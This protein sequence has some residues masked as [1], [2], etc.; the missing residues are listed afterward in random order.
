MP[1]A[2]ALQFAGR[3][4][5][6]RPRESVDDE[7]LKQGT[8]DEGLD[9]GSEQIMP[10]LSIF[11]GVDAAGRFNL[12]EANNNPNPTRHTVCRSRPARED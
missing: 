6:R 5:P 1:S 9:A 12:R 11:T 3:R 2:I 4:F 8:V 10:G 7:M